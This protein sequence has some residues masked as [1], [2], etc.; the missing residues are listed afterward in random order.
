MRG[1]VHDSVDVPADDCAVPDCNVRS[2]EDVADEGGVG[3]Q[4]DE[5]FV[6]DVVVVEI[7]DGAGTVE[8][9]HVFLGRLDLESG[10]EGV[11]HSPD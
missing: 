7:H 1:A 6:E 9:F 2:H 4:E 5:A 10:E 11:G 3:G 8:G